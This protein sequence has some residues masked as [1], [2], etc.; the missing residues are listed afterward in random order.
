MPS[1]PP[2][3]QDLAW[4]E[5]SPSS[6][7][8]DA[9]PLSS[10]AEPGPDC[11]TAPVLPSRSSLPVVISDVDYVPAIFLKHLFILQ[12]KAVSYARLLVSVK[13]WACL[14]FGFA[15]RQVL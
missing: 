12:I 9:A 13:A 11:C 14:L 4:Q 5:M 10:Q 3:C 2:V 7:Q 6:A 1:P 8:H 15:S